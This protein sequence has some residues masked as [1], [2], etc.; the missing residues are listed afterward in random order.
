VGILLEPAGVASPSMGE[1]SVVLY[2]APALFFSQQLHCLCS[3]VNAS[4]TCIPNIFGGVQIE[5]CYKDLSL[6]FYYI[7]QWLCYLAAVFFAF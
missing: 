1:Q 3:P 2:T 4:N 5:Q 6:F 7:F